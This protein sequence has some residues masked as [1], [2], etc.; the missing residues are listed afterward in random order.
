LLEDGTFII[1]NYNNGQPFA[2]FLPGIS[3]LK[4][5]PMWAFYCNRGQGVACFG[6][7]SKDSSITEFNPAVK[8]YGMTPL[9]GFRTF[10]KVTSNS[11]TVF[12]EPFTNDESNPKYKVTQRMFIRSYELLF[13][14][15]NHTLGLKTNVR[16]FTLPEEPRAALVRIV[17]FENISK[18]PMTI[19]VIDGLPKVTPYWMSDWTLKFTTNTAQAWATIK[20]FDKTGVPFYRVKVEINDQPEV[21]PVSKGHFYFGLTGKGN[22][23][24]KAGII[25]DPDVVFGEDTSFRSP[26]EFVRA[27]KFSYPKSQYADNRYPSAMS[28]FKTTLKSKA[29]ET[30]YS[31]AGHIASEGELNDYFKKVQS[32]DYFNRKVQANKNVVEG[33]TRSMFTSSSKKEFDLYC[34]QTYLDNALRGGIPVILDGGSKK[35]VFYVYSRKHGDLERDYN[36]FYLSPSYYSQGNGNFRDVNQNKRSDVFFNPN[37]KDYNVLSFYNLLQLDG[38][39]P[40]LIKGI[41]FWIDSGSDAMIKLLNGT[42]DAKDVKRVKE[43]FS[44][45]FEP[46]SLLLFLEKEKIKLKVSNDEFLSMVLEI[47]QQIDVADHG[48]AWHGSGYWVDHWTYNLDLLENYLAVYPEQEKDILLDKKEFTYFDNPF[49][50]VS[51]SERYVK[52]AGKVRQFGSVVL[53]KAKQA[54]IKHR[55]S[56]QSV[57]REHGHHGK[58][59]KSNLLGKLLCLIINKMSSLD[60]EGIGVELE[61]DKPGWYDALNGLPGVFGSSLPETFELKR[62]VQFLIDHLGKFGLKDDYQ[63]NLS[64]EI[65]GFLTGLN[66]LLEDSSLSPYGFWDKASVLKENFRMASNMGVTGVE[67]TITYAQ[68]KSFLKAALAKLNRGIDKAYDATTGLYYTYFAFEAAEFKEVNKLSHQGHQLVWINKFKKRPLSHFLEGE[69]RYMKTETNIEKARKLHQAVKKSALYDKTLGMYKLNASLKNE[70]TDIGRCTVFAPGWL[71]N[72]SIWTHME[73]KYLLE[74]IRVGLYKEFFEE[75]AKV[76]SC[77]LDPKIYGRSILENSSF[78]VSSAFPNKKMWGRGCVA[79]L[80]GATA[81]FLEMWLLM[82][83]GKNPFRVDHKGKLSLVFNPAISKDYFTKDGKFSFMFLSRTLV[84]YHNSKRID[85]YSSGF[86]VKKIEISWANDGMDTIEGP[87]VPEELALK[88]REQKADKIEVY[89]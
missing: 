35:V 67:K 25:I 49:V 32:E 65:Y 14:E 68:L 71:E 9:L 19:E 75:F 31:M 70:P 79:R 64:E 7:S 51:R 50:V 39:N 21:Y 42:V 59:Y 23:L 47:A 29:K 13:E 86:N 4:G 10:I 6:V 76:G 20:N 69:V 43:F 12:Y 40:L 82:T 3:G 57:V 83:L 36:N 77:F 52:V 18:Q 2:S 53:D 34:R 44:K 54:Q 5:I 58:I 41:V 26:N 48:E 24:K 45:N 88:I 72:E 15:V 89:F 74:L 8:A 37:I 61:G 66:G 16:Y 46:G 56:N 27:K 60:S 17:D 38:F 33:V 84:T 85:T 63:I 30:L 1:E 80:S 28:Y 81:E 73:Y 78:I 87:V 22:N 62:N 11:K 55:I